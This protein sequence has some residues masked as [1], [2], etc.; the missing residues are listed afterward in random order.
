MSLIYIKY[1]HH[2]YEDFPTLYI[3]TKEIVKDRMHYDN[4]C[5]SSFA[6]YLIGV[7]NTY[8]IFYL[9]C[10]LITGGMENVRCKQTINIPLTSFAQPI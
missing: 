6:L 3:R 9:I 1:P 7:F 4:A 10:Y 5:Y 8:F 2:K